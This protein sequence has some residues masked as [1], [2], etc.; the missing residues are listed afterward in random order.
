VSGSSPEQVVQLLQV[1]GVKPPIT[2]HEVEQRRKTLVK[3]WHPDRF[4]RDAAL[5]AEAHEQLS[6]I[7]VAFGELAELYRSGERWW[8][9]QS[10]PTARTRDVQP[11]ATSRGRREPDVAAARYP[12][13]AA[14][15]RHLEALL[16]Q[17]KKARTSLGGTTSKAKKFLMAAI[18]A[19]IVLKV[20][21]VR[22]LVGFALLG[23]MVL[24]FTMMGLAGRN[25]RRAISK[26]LDSDL[27][28]TSCGCRLIEDYVRGA[29]S[30]LECLI[31]SSEDILGSGACPN[32]GEGFAG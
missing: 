5:Q 28:C 21:G 6:R 24:G 22:G 10:G 23:A 13:P 25:E 12:L 29:E 7:N 14:T 4:Q 18:G 27:Q 16:S 11:A 20:M 30:Q 2:W 19:A 9:T 17:A 8:E 26:M 3:V 1:L 31:S 32:C 15:Q